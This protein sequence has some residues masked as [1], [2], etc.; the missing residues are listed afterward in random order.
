MEALALRAGNDRALRMKMGTLVMNQRRL[1]VGDDDLVAMIE[2]S[3]K[4]SQDDDE[5][6]VPI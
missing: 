4:P 6:G 2:A 5:D 3:G 1:G